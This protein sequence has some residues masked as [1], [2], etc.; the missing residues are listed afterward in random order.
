[1]QYETVDYEV[2]D[3]VAIITFNRPDRLNAFNL[4]LQQD[5]TQALGE[6]DRDPDVRVV[7]VTGA[8]GRAF[9]AGYDIK[10]A[11]ELPQGDIAKW[12]ERLG[13]DFE[14]TATVWNC[15][16]PVIAMIDGFCLGGGLEF[17]QMCDVRF[18]S[19]DAKFG[20]VET[21]FALGLATL[22]MPWVVGARGRELIYTGDQIDAQEAHRVGLVNRVF[23][24]AD[25][26]AETMKIA[27]RMSRVALACLQWNKRAINN[28]YDCQGFVAAMRYG[29][30]AS[31]IIAATGTPEYK[32]FDDIS[33]S[34]GLSEALKWRQE[35]FA[36]YE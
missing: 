28:M 24:K 35:Q 36:P 33:R 12:R 31:A 15:S 18:C 13:G 21:R 5:F 19:D 27:K 30:E 8:G 34:K 14:F 9:S 29:I 32:A 6:A 1:M 22:I 16:K 20:V 10:A 11:S 3:R 7:V 25:L 17:A 4:K 23:P 26:R 2:D